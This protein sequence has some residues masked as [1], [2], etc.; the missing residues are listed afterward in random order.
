MDCTLCK[1]G[2]SEGCL[3]ESHTHHMSPPFAKACMDQ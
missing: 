2:G 1:M 3:E